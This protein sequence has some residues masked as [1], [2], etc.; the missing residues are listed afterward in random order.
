MNICFLFVVFRPTQEFSFMWRHYHYLWRAT[1]FYLYSALKTIE[2][3]GFFNEPHL[4]WHKPTLYN[5][6][7]RGPVTLIP[8]AEPLA[9]ELSLPVLKN[10]RP[11]IEPRPLA[12]K[13]DALPLRHRRGL[14]EYRT[15]ISSCAF[16][17]FQIIVTW[18]PNQTISPNEVGDMSLK[19]S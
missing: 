2:Q 6:H 5:G 16:R 9:V 18:L 12:C 11:G 8:V 17:K 13:T 1:I 3:W 10:F 4:L 15:F 7:P 19:K 14:N